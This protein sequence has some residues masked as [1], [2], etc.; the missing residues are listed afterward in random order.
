VLE[1]VLGGQ[2]QLVT[3]NH[4]LT[5]LEHLLVRKFNFSAAAAREVRVELEFMAALA[6]PAHVP[7]VCRDPDDDHVLAV[8]TDGQANW[9]VTGDKDLL[10]LGSHRGVEIITPAGLIELADDW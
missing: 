2:I 6:D 4:L 10:D 5:E 3:S 8:A 1:L 7:P 9:I